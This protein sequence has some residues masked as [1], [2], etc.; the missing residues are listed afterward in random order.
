VSLRCALQVLQQL[1]V[2]YTVEWFTENSTNAKE[3]EDM[4]RVRQEIPNLTLM[5][6]SDLLWTWQQMWSADAFVM[7][8]SGYSFVPAVVNTKGI[9]IHAPALG[10]KKCKIA[11]S[12]SHWFEP[13]D[14]AGALPEGVGSALRQKVSG[15]YVQQ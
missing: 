10:I 7:S 5:L 14:G 15:C 12:P 11:C 8:K 4:Q 3:H 1:N 13:V 2:D 6:D 9:V